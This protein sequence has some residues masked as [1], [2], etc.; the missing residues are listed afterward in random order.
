MDILLI[1][2]S[3]AIFIWEAIKE[4]IETPEQREAARSA[5]IYHEKL[6]EIDRLMFGDDF[7]KRFK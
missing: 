3:I 2:G 5:R 6:N 4:H 1:L 7:P